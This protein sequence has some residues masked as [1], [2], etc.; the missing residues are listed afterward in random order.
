M[1]REF[2]ALAC[3]IF[4]LVGCL[5]TSGSLYA[6]AEEFTVTT[7]GQFEEPW[8]LEFLPDGRLLIS[9][10]VGA[11]KLLDA[12]GGI[13]EVTGLPEVDH[14]GQG[15]FGD[16]VLHPDF[17]ENNLLYF[18]YIEAGGDDT[19]G[20]VVARGRLTLAGAGGQ[21]QD[22]EVLWRQVPKVTGQGHYI[23]SGTGHE[24]ESRQGRAAQR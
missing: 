12:D 20:A 16:I 8:A 21:L 22:I 19:R 11:I 13:G 5:A 2:K 15:G 3:S 23:R 17:V 24:F 18:S 4:G 7:I 14:G 10:M 6:Q 9:E 1:S